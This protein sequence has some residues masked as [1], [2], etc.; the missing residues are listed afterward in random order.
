M[1]APS[2]VSRPT[3]SRCSRCRA[4]SGL[5]TKL[6]ENVRSGTP[7]R[8]RRPSSTE[9]ASRIAAT[10]TYET[11]LPARRARMSNAPPARSASFETVATT[12]PVESSARTA[13]PGAR[14]VVPD[15][16]DEPERRLQPVLHREAVAED[17]GDGLDDAEHGEEGAEP[18]ERVA[19][20]RRRSP[21]GSPGRSRTA[22]A[23][24]RPS[25]RSR[26]RSRSGSCRAGAAPPRRAAGSASGCPVAPDRRP[27]ARSRPCYRRRAAAA[28]AEERRTR[29]GVTA[30]R[31]ACTRCG[32]ARAPRGRVS[33]SPRRRTHPRSPRTTS[34]ASRPRTRGCASRPGRGTSDRG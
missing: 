21:A 11:T 30:G 17:A 23:P 6:S 7:I 12:S 18:D 3:S 22:S 32:A 27:G 28:R 34:P 29:F 15:D 25:R 9:V 13:S 26:R 16:L 20:R 31:A 10:T 8:T 2:A 24:A 5:I 14:G 33:R 19:G 4:W 1:S